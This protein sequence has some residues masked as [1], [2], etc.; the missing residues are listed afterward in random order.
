MGKTDVILK[1]KIENL[2]NAGDLVSVSAGYARNYLLP[3]NLCILAGKEELAALQVRKEHIRKKAQKD[4]E[5]LTSLAQ[6]I[7]DLTLKVPVKV[8][9]T[10]KLFGSVTSMH[11]VDLLKNIEISLDKKQLHI[12]PPV[13]DLGSF[14]IPVDLGHAVHATLKIDVVAE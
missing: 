14:S 10:G 3:K 7:N 5:H 8:G 6:K 4:L 2:G 1:Q 9:D 11:L 12:D 13:R